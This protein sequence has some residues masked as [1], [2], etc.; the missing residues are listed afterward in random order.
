MFLIDCSFCSCNGKYVYAV[1][2]DSAFRN[3]GYASKLIEEAKKQMGDFLWLIPADEE[4]FDYYSKFG[5]E[6][7]LYSNSA[8][9]NKIEFNEIDEIISELYEGS[10]FENP[11]GMLYSLKFFLTAIRV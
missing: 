3:R 2:T 10:A 4:L 6:T 1:A 9:E 5:F 11:K 7:K 8:F